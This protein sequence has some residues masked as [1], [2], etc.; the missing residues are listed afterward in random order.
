MLVPLMVLQIVLVDLAMISAFQKLVSVSIF[1]AQEHVKQ[2]VPLKSLIVIALI[3][4]PY[5]AK[6]LRDVLLNLFQ[7]QMQLVLLLLMLIVHLLQLQLLVILIQMGKLFVKQTNVLQILVLL[8]Q[9]FAK[10]IQMARHNVS[11]GLV[12]IQMR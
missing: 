1:L 4:L 3:Q 11:L 8:I 5:F 2:N 6:I 12:S 7:A 9:H 10:I